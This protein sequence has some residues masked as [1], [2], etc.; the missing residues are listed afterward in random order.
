M[1][2]KIIDLAKG[3]TGILGIQVTPEISQAVTSVGDIQ[4]DAGIIQVVIQIVIGLVTLFHLLKP[5]KKND[6][7]PY[8]DAE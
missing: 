7:S 1:K 5:K 8:K 3:T 2:E 6:K 4:S